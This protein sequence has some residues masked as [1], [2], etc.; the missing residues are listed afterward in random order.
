VVIAFGLPVLGLIGG[1]EFRR[2]Y[3]SLLWLAAAGCVDLIV[4]VF[5]PAIVAANRAHLAFGARLLATAVLLTAS[6]V[7]APKIGAVGVAISVFANAL[8]QAALLGLVLLH[9]MRY[10]RAPRSQNRIPS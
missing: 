5:E 4:V 8:T 6:V 2:G 7:L 3:V 10:E 1:P 9:L